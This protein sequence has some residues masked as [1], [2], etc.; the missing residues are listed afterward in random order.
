MDV[1]Y[2]TH[3]D[4]GNVVEEPANDGVDACVM[5]LIDIPLLQFRVSS[6]PTNKVPSN[7]QG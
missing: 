7:H 6:L 5:D 4:E 1:S 3:A 2:T